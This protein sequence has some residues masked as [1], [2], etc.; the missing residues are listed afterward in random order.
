MK[1]LGFRKV[2]YRMGCNRVF[3]ELKNARYEYDNPT[4]IVP[5]KATSVKHTNTTEHKNETATHV[6]K[7]LLIYASPV[8]KLFYIPTTAS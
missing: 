8:T 4:H 5:S 1:Q 7:C 6:Q 3:G 2:H